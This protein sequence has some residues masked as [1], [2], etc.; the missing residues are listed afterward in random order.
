MS[1]VEMFTKDDCSLCEELKKR[2]GPMAV[3]LGVDLRIVNLHEGDPRFNQYRND[4]PVLVAENGRTVSGNISDDTLWKLFLSLTPP[5]R[6]YYVAKFLQALAIVVVFFGFMYGLLG[7][8][9][10]DLY[11][12]L[13]GIVIFVVGWTIEKHEA[14]SRRKR[15]AGEKKR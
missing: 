2:A 12:F 8:M 5:P 1:V 9:W 4:F 15:F 7:D 10:T 6:I 11:F 3:E 13:A 14:R